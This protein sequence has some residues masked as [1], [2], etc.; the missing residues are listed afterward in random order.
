MRQQILAPLDAVDADEPIARDV[1]AAIAG[2][3]GAARG[4]ARLDDSGRIVGRANTIGN[5]GPL[6]RLSA[7]RF[8][9]TDLPTNRVWVLDASGQTVGRLLRADGDESLFFQP[10]G[11]AAPGDGCLYVASD[12]RIGVY[13]IEQ[14]D[15]MPAASELRRRC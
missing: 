1:Q 12:M 11:I 3:G 7:D 5:V 14:A 8:L 4:V 13:R 2:R 10:R 15:A 6:A 9:M